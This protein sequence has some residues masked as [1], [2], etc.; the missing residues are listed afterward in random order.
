MNLAPFHNLAM[1]FG[2]NGYRLYMI[3]GT[4]RDYLLGRPVDDFDLVS[5]ATP[6]QIQ[7]FLPEA[8]YRFS[9]YGN[10]KY[11]LGY[12]KVDITTLREEAGYKDYRHPQS[13]SFVTDISKDY[14]RRDF[15][16]NAIYID[17]TMKVFDFADGLTHLSERK[18]VM[19]GEPNARLQEDPLRILRAL[20]FVIKLDFTLGS[21]LA[22]AISNNA[23]LL[24]YL[25]PAKI[26]AEIEKMEHMDMD[27]TMIL[28]NE[29]GLRA[30]Y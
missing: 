15:T 12:Q 24:E 19:I 14:R 21:N 26:N 8:N 7:D 10:V 13:I 22:K 1:L 2:K 16:I 23:D 11:R 5:D 3:G 30:R 27:K 28:L 4:S 6:T 20:R 17:E 18:I 29:F 9:H 25:T